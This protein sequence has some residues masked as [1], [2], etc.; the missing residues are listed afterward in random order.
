MLE[1]DDT[2]NWMSITQAARGRVARELYLN[3]QMGLEHLQPLPDWPGPG[4][5][6][7]LGYTECN[8]RA[9]WQTWLR[10]LTEEQRETKEAH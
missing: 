5:A 1:Q 6:F 7:A 10:Y 8:Q 3:Y 4:T 9:F 2:E